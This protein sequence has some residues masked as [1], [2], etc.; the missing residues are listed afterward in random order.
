[1]QAECTMYM[2][3]NEKNEEKN[4]Y[5]HT[6]E[7]VDKGNDLQLSISE[8]GI[9]NFWWMR[10]DVCGCESRG[11]LSTNRKIFMWLVKAL[12]RNPSRV[13]KKMQFNLDVKNQRQ[14]LN[15]NGMS[16]HAVILWVLSKW[17]GMRQCHKDIGFVWYIE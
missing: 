1:M 15:F 6:T 8:N 11:N 12:K 16:L 10:F 14:R 2:K 13:N 17:N 5:I 3:S 7:G 4:I 9:Y